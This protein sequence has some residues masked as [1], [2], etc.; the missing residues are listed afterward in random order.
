MSTFNVLPLA[1]NRQITR[2]CVVAG[3]GM[4]ALGSILAACGGDNAAPTATSRSAPTPAAASPVV[5]TSGGAPTS[6]VSSAASSTGQTAG[7]GGTLIYNGGSNPSG[8]D[9]HIVGDTVA[10]NVLDNL[11]DRLVRLDAKT[12]LPTPSLAEKYDASSDGL[13]YTFQLRKGVKFHNGREMKA[14]DVKY[15]FE[16]IQDPKVPAVAKGYFAA[17][18]HIEVPDD[19]TVRLVYKSVFAPLVIA[20]TRL[21]TA[22]VPREEVEKADQW[23]AHPIGSGPFKFVSFTKDQS[24]VLDRNPDYWEQ[25]LPRLDRVEQRVITKDETSVINLQTG[26]IQA[27]GV[28]ASSLSKIKGAKGINVQLIQSTFWP[29]LSVNC[30]KPPFNDV[31]VRQAIRLGIKRDDIQALAFEN[32]GSISNTHLPE[33]NPYRAEVQGWNYDPAK[34]KQ[35]LADAGLGAGFKTT[36]R[37]TPS[38]AWEPPAAQIIQDNLK[39]LNITVA[40]EQIEATT[41][42]SEVFA[43]S[44]FEMSM[45]AHASKVDPDL[46]MYDILHSGQLGTKNYTKFSDPEMD[47]LLDMGRATADVEARKKIYA[48]AQK[49][50]VERTGYFVLNLQ[51]QVYGLRDTVQQFT[52]LPTGELRWKETSLTR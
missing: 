28:A 2:R 30:S 29:H 27:T 43:Q 33:G 18:D 7:K 41:W 8:F 23:A 12:Q 22:I 16:R 36:M 1:T 50:F 44:Q 26:D 45:T 32:L 25:G 9:P 31:R 6:A 46:S 17:L 13:T 21:E 49:I 42:F 47:R 14:A 48:D 34:A 24:V 52:L 19:Y 38:T 4:A 40:I 11:F 5:S 35:L 37:I 51:Q 20:L 10:W 3:I 15:S 39:A